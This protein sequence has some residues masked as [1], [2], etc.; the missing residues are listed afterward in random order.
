MQSELRAWLAR[1]V[2][3]KTLSNYHSV[4]D[5]IERCLPC[6]PSRAGRRGPH[7]LTGLLVRALAAFAPR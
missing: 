7:Q 5:H 2:K 1:E 3:L 6:R 4:R